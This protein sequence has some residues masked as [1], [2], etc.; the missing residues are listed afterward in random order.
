MRSEE[1]VTAYTSKSAPYGAKALRTI[2]SGSVSLQVELR[3]PV[4]CDGPCGGLTGLDYVEFGLCDHNVC[5][6]CYETAE[7]ADHEGIHGCCNADCLE[8]ARIENRRRGRT[9][10]KTEKRRAKRLRSEDSFRMQYDNSDLQKFVDG[11]RGERNSK[12]TA[13]ESDGAMEALYYKCRELFSRT[14]YASDVTNVS[15][16]VLYCFVVHASQ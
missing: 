5:R 9:V 1:S 8:L 14:N 10:R 7:S 13:S 16:A 2:S 12:S 6:N 4:Q 11:L 15:L 3:V